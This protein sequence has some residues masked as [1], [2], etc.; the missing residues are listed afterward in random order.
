MIGAGAGAAA[1]VSVLIAIGQYG[2][3]PA[4]GFWECSGRA[5]GSWPV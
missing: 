4:C 3:S 1:L 2:D 5:F